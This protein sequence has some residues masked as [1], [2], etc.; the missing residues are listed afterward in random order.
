[1]VVAGCALDVEANA[2]RGWAHR[3]RGFTC[4]SCSCARYYKYEEGYTPIVPVAGFRRP[5]RA[6][7]EMAGDIDYAGKRGCD[8][9][10][11][12]AVTLVAGKWPSFAATSP[13]AALANLCGGAPAEGCRWPT[14]AAQPVAK[15]AYHLIRWRNV[16]FGMYFFQLSRPNRS[17][18]SN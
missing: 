9:I 18:S 13:A 2:G 7:A 3:D 14:N 5:H 11:G 10:G 4:I 6:S 15:L 1:V 12:S 8:R 17:G 16:L